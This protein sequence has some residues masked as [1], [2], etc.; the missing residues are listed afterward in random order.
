MQKNT[1]KERIRILIGRLG[2][3]EFERFMCDL[4]PSIYPDFDL[5]EPSFNSIGKTTKGK[6]D[7]HVYHS[8]D[9]T[10]TAIICT[11]RQSDRHSKILCDINKLE[12]TKFSSK[13]RRVVL[14]TN[15]P[16]KDDVEVYRTACRDHGWE[17]DPLSLER[18]TQHT[19]D[20]ADLLLNYFGEI[21]PGSTTQ[22]AQLRRFDCGWRLREAREDLAIPI[23]LLIEAIDFPIEREW[24]S[25]ECN[26]LDVAEQY[27]IAVSALTGISSNWLKYGTSMKYPVEVIYDDQG[28]KINAIAAEGLLSAC[29]AIEPKSMDVVLI[30]HFTEHR[31]RVYS[32]GFSLDF[33][34]WM[35]DTHHIPIIFELFLSIDLKLRHP[36]GKVISK[37]LMSELRA[38]TKHPSTSFKKAGDNSYWFDDLLHLLH[39][40]QIGEEHCS[41]HGEWFMQLQKAFRAY[42]KPTPLPAERDPFCDI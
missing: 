16:L 21:S 30:V 23:S 19:M 3:N 31:W 15:T 12:S 35:G 10:Y 17:L 20:K 37:N 26:K 14:C 32:F 34:N 5:L 42:V 22:T 2:G 27:V 40:Y 18:I 25:I 6:C 29:M 28:E 41:H 11:T 36:R 1:F 33:W 24:K 4:L 38:G 39:R 9:D 8:R 7:A 13:I